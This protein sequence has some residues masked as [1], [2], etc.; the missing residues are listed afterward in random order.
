MKVARR[1]RE[2]GER[3]GTISAYGLEFVRNWRTRVMEYTNFK[4]REVTAWFSCFSSCV[5][6]FPGG[7]HAWRQLQNC[8]PRRLQRHHNSPISR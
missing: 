7:Y 8:A 2:G 6:D 3:D 5:P 4:S 1:R